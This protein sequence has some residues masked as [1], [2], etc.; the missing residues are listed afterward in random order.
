MQLLAGGL[1]RFGNSPLA[2]ARQEPRAAGVLRRDPGVLRDRFSVTGGEG[3]NAPTEAEHNGTD[4]SWRIMATKP[5]K[6]R[7]GPPVIRTD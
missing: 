6:A 2:F 3:P 1:L 7:F 4:A 5:S